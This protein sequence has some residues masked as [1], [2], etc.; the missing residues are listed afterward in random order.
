MDNGYNE[1]VLKYFLLLENVICY[2]LRIITFFVGRNYYLITDIC[3]LKSSHFITVNYKYPLHT[4]FH[5]PRSNV[6]LV[7]AVTMKDK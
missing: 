7:I 6:S 3:N 2:L 5:I 1:P 4:R